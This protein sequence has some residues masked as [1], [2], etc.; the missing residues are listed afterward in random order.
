MKRLP[1]LTTA[2][3]PHSH[4]FAMSKPSVSKPKN[5]T[6]NG[7][8]F[9]TDD[10][11]KMRSGRAPL[12]R[13]VPYPNNPRIHPPAE[14]TIL[15]SLLKKRGADQPIVVDENWV[16]LKGHGRQQAALAAGLEDFPFVQRL[17]LSEEEKIA[18]RIEDNSVPLLAAWDRE[19]IRVEIG[20][21]K[22]AGYEMPLLGFGETQLV[23]FM[24]TPGPPGSFQVFGEDIETEFC[25]PKCG[26]AWSGN[27]A[28]GKAKDMPNGKSATRAAKP[29]K[30]AR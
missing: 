1:S 19:L 5:Y 30:G 14:I 29:K 11:P 10:G 17:D 22:L 16:I 23:Q 26:Y 28:A 24:T 13:F 2:P 3:Q 6:T 15:T 8:P 20:A 9:V 12:S 27:A 7:D 21:L 18:I 4:R 25:C